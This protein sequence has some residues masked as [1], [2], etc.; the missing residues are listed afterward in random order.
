MNS[1]IVLLI[2][3]CLVGVVSNAQY[4]PA[5]GQP[6]TTAI[7]TDSTVIVNWASQCQLE[8]GWI[9]MEDTTFGKATYGAASDAVGKANNQVVSLGDGGSAV[10]TFQKP[11][12]DG[13]GW[14][15]VVFENALNDGF[16]ELAF[17][18]VSADGIN[19][20]RFPAHSLT[21]DSAQTDPF[22]DTDPTMINNLAGKYKVEYG[23]PFDLSELPQ[24][25]NLSE[26]THVRI[27]DV[28][29]S[30]DPNVGSIDTAGNLINDPYP[31]AFAS[32][33][34]DLDGVGVIHQLVGIDEED[35]NASAV[36][37][38]M[39]PNPAKDYLIIDGI[40]DAGLEIYNLNGQ[41]MLSSVSKENQLKIDLSRF[42]NGLY[43]VKVSNGNNTLVKKLVVR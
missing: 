25:L 34:F 28:V 10:L 6:G 23:T 21:Q 42:A 9:F 37:F 18:E 31:T 2:I 13:P 15:F 3:F 39:Y 1:R 32:G 4:A 16:L 33:G 5:V 27:V 12:I 20:T 19:Y 22:G 43:L 7:H 26:I 14:D 38:T 17:V 11:I 40:A 36:S 30:I 41:L 24:Y 35:S 8:R 29:G